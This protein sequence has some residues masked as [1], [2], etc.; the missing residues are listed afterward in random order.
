MGLFGFGKKKETACECASAQNT[1]EV[2]AACACGN[3]CSIA[4]IEKARLIVLGACCAKSSQTFENVKTA[5]KELNI[6][7]EVIN[8]GDMAEI[9]KYGVMSTPAFVIDSKV[10]AMGKLVKVEEAKK[11]LQQAGF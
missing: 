10:V 2:K 6:Q 11:L 9:A 5:A 8:I 4:D 7:D 3:E 1:Q